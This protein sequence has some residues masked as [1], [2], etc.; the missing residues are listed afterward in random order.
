MTEAILQRLDE[1]DAKLD[2]HLTRTSRVLGKALLDVITDLQDELSRQDPEA[3]TISGKVGRSPFV[4]AESLK[5]L[6]ME[7]FGLEDAR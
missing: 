5:G 4:H 6:I 7:L 2:V 1:I 3:H